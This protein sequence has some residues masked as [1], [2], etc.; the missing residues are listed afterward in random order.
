[1][2]SRPGAIVLGDP[3]S[4]PGG[5]VA[6][7]DSFSKIVQNPDGANTILIENRQSVALNLQPVVGA[8]QGSSTGGGRPGPGGISIP[9]LS[10]ASVPIDP[11]ADVVVSMARAPGQ[12]MN[13]LQVGGNS[14][15]V[16]VGIPGPR[17]IPY[18]LL[19][20]GGYHV[21]ELYPLRD[22]LIIGGRGGT[23]AAAS[24]RQ[25]VVIDPTGS[26]ASTAHALLTPGSNSLYPAR[27]G[28]SQT[29]NATDP[30]IMAV[31]VVITSLG[32]SSVASDL[33]LTG[34]PWL[35]TIGFPQAG[36]ADVQL[37]STSAAGAAGIIQSSGIIPLPGWQS[38]SL[39]NSGGTTG[40]A[41]R[42]T[43]WVGV[44]HDPPRG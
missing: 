44:P 12:A 14:E 9:A 13:T 33:V 21:E 27:V 18:L 37:F 39:V 11:A 32:A 43:Y 25:D 36:T 17:T 31:E 6:L 7:P 16:A 24:Q 3:R 1:M 42:T 22:C 2:A 30:V 10:I 20:G 34:A 4:Y 35:Q 15:T 5:G 41:C 23:I 19:D 40:I 29:P 28:W 26:L 8:V 38:V